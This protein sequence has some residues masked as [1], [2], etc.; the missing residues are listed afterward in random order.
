MA[1]RD[2][3]ADISA[4]QEVVFNSKRSDE[5]SADTF[6]WLAGSLGQFHQIAFDAELLRQRYVGPHTVAQ[7]LEALQ[8]HLAT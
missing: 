5:L 6:V 4:A 2:E 7:L 8:A 3:S 1:P